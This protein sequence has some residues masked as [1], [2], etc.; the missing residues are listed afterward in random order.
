MSRS[1]RE[2]GRDSPFPENTQYRN[3]ASVASVMIYRIVNKEL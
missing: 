1:S 2:K 3:R